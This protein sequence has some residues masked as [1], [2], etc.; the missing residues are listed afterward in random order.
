MVGTLSYAL[1]SYFTTRARMFENTRVWGSHTTLWPTYLL[2]AIATLS[3]M[4][5]L[6]TLLAYVCGVGAAN[7]VSSFTSYAGYIMLVTEFIAWAVS[8]GLF[9]MA[10]TGQDLWGYSCGPNAD[11]IE[12]QVKS[13]V[14]FGRLCQAQVSI[15]E[16]EQL[17]IN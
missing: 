11:R 7:K 6:L 3:L 8:A 14:D 9:K 13:F 15:I 10:E 1:A 17:D 5:S 2:L 16:L 12:E 4:M